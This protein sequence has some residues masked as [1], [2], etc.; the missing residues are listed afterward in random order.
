VQQRYEIKG[1]KPLKKGLARWIYVHS[2][3]LLGMIP[4]SWIRQQYSASTIL[5]FYHAVS[6]LS[7][8]HLQYLYPIRSRVEF[9]KDLDF[10]LENYEPVRPGEDL[11]SVLSVRGSRQR[12]LL[13]FDDGLSECHRYV[14]PILE[15]RNIQAVFFINTAFLDNRALFFRYKLSLILAKLNSAGINDA[16]ISE[17]RQMLGLKKKNDLAGRIMELKYDQV[18]LIDQLAETLNLSFADYLERERPYMSIDQILDLHRRGFIVGA[19]SDDHP[20]YA[21]LT[22]EEIIRQT[23]RSSEIMQT[24]VPEDLKLF[25]FPFTDYGIGSD[26][27]RRMRDEKI[28]DYCFGCAGTRGISPAENSDGIGSKERQGRAK[29]TNC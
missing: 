4:F 12:V 21:E 6:D 22:E 7:P 5:P 16:V 27:I 28:F 1:I 20:L 23:K 29:R 26:V 3:D 14:A 11:K 19:H 17:I 13:S 8:P 10:L 15:E 2:A 18:C 24:I 9:A 25:S